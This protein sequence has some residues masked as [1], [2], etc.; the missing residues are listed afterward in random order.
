MVL[1]VGATGHLGWEVAHRAHARS[2]PTRALVR[3]TSDPAA[4][5]GLEAMGVETVVGDLRDPASLLAAC[6]GVAGVISSASTVANPSAGRIA[7]VDGA[8]QLD[9]VDA[10]RRAG[11]AHAVFVSFSSNMR[12]DTPLH[13]AKRAVEARLR[14][15]GMTY[16]VLRPS[17]FME[18]FLAPTIGF[19]YA[20]RHATL[21]GAGDNPISWI[22]IRDVAEAAV[23]ALVRP[24]ARNAVL[25]LGGPQTL[26]P[27]EAVRIFE[28]VSGAPFQVDHVPEAVLEE[29]LRAADPRA[30]S[31]A[32]LSL[33]FAHGDAVD[34]ER[35]RA[36]LGA[37][38]TTVRAYAR[39]ALSALAA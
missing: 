18:Y 3:T 10:A 25:E 7:D 24:D 30:R 23:A 14:E 4:V 35:A 36:V 28:E 32:G 1:V 15:S 33:D 39:R 17:F 34:G 38:E 5:R 2:F 37:P 12:S 26:T 11:V 27:K 22:A 9:L 21:F 16:T 13:R 20:H 6:R 29:Q 31:L 8:G 19:D